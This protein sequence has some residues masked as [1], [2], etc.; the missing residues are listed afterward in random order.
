[1]SVT[2]TN[3]FT[4]ATGNGA[5]TV[6]PFTFFA[7]DPS[8]VEVT[9]NGLIQTSGF[10]VIANPGAGGSVTFDTA[11]ANG[12]AILMSLAADFE[13]NVDFENAGPYLPAAVDAALDQAAARDI[14]LNEA[15]GRSIKAPAGEGP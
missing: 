9:V 7:P 3:A 10:S 11:P 1:M 15:L 2:A 8:Q 14:A 13:Q 5:A 4:T 12:A 6:F